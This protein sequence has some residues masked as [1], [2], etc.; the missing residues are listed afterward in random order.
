MTV[1]Q[2]GQ[3]PEHL[4]LADIE[5]RAHDLTNAVCDLFVVRHGPVLL[6]FSTGRTSASG[7]ATRAARVLL[8]QTHKLGVRAYVGG[9]MPFD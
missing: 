2:K 7:T 3:P 5:T 6:R 8:D 9:S 1:E 4:A